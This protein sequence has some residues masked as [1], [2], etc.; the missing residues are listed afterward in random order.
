MTEELSR[1]EILR[2]VDSSIKELNVAEIE[3]RDNFN[4]GARN[5][6]MNALKILKE[7]YDEI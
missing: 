5:R 4:N 6:I 3:C 1:T 7:I 2:K